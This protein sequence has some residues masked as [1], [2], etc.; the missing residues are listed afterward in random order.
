MYY[1]F[2]KKYILLPLALVVTAVVVGYQAYSQLDHRV[3][4][5]QRQ[6][7][8]LQNRLDQLDREVGFLSRQLEYY[9]RYGAQYQKISQT[10]VKPIDRFLFSDQFYR[11]SRIYGFSDF[12]ITFKPRQTVPNLRVGVSSIRNGL[13][14][15]NPVRLRWDGPSDID[16][17]RIVNF[18]SNHL[19]SFFRLRRCDLSMNADKRPTSIREIFM[20]NRALIS[21]DCSLVFF[22]AMPRAFHDG[23]K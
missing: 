11:L 9:L 17:F 12:I 23:T 20:Q 16:H 22:N 1:F 21:F 3:E 15:A 6:L 18:Y 2:F 7:N 13:I 14:A 4:E 19:S 8:R 10:L 5:K